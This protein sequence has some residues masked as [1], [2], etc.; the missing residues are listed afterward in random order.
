MCVVVHNVPDHHQ[1]HVNYPLEDKLHVVAT[2]GALNQGSRVEG[3]EYWHPDTTQKTNQNHDGHDFL[4]SRPVHTMR[5]RDLR[6]DTSGRGHLIVCIGQ[7]NTQIYSN[8]SDLPVQVLLTY[9]ANQ[10]FQ[11]SHQYLLVVERK[12]SQFLRFVSYSLYAV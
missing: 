8:R 10:E 6:F 4:C 12:T 3:N 2:M 7:E 1:I 5:P 9:D 11:V